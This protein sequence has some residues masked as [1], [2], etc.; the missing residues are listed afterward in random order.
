[1]PEVLV[2]RGRCSRSATT[3]VG[4]PT[5]STWP[6]RGG[7]GAAERARHRRSTTQTTPAPRVAGRSSA[8]GL[9]LRSRAPAGPS[10]PVTRSGP[11]VREAQ[12][13][14]ARATGPSGR[15]RGARP[16]Q[17]DE[18]GGRREHRR[19]QLAVREG[20]RVVVARVRE[21]RA[22]QAASRL[23]QVEA[24][25]NGRSAAPWE[26]PRTRGLGGP[27]GAL[28]GSL[29]SSSSP[30]S[31]EARRPGTAGPASGRVRAGRAPPAEHASAHAGPARRQPRSAGLGEQPFAGGDGGAPAVRPHLAVGLAVAA[32]VERQRGQP[33]A[34]ACSPISSWFSLR[35]PAPSRR[36]SPRGGAGRNSRPGQRDAVRG[37][38]D[39]LGR[40]CPGRPG[41]A[42]SGAAGPGRRG[43]GRG[44]WTSSSHPSL[45]NG[46]GVMYYAPLF[47]RRSRARSQ[48]RP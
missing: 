28:S 42:G 15:A 29:S 12:S 24:V 5:G 9:R 34:A 6:W 37:D 31:R 39:R 48:R 30:A 3:R 27:P 43:A 18:L 26:R 22:R 40:P 10:F 17:A 35:L 41:P 2:R 44:R 19:Q 14:V 25:R 45:A 46:Y 8:R 47:E 36:S 23:D 21:E 20:H 16:R 4:S 33:A 1:M 38:R 7:G 32:E 11:A 13:M